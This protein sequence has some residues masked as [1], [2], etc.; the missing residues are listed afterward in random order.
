MTFEELIRLI[1]VGSL[2]LNIWFI[3]RL[4]QRFEKVGEREKDLPARVERLE[5][6]TGVR[7]GV[8]ERPYTERRD[9]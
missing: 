7:P 1:T 3:K 4:I 6:I 8:V 2:G 9:P 5:Q